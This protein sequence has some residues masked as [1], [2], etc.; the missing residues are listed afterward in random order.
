MTCNFQLLLLKKE[1]ST[2]PDQRRAQLVS[3]HLLFIPEK[4]NCISF[5]AYSHAIAFENQFTIRNQ[6]ND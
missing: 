1:R 2:I 6:E 4:L 5:G 3:S